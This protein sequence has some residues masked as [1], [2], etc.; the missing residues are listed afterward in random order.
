MQKPHLSPDQKGRAIVVL[1]KE[2]YIKEMDRI[3]RD[4]NTYTLIQ[5]DPTLQYKRALTSL[6]DEGF[7]LGILDKNE[8]SY[9]VPLAPHISAIYYLPKVHKKYKKDPVDPPGRPI[10]SGIDYNL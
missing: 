7:S 4:S 1:N 6:V 9:L 3:L 10:V 2:D 8:R 5:T